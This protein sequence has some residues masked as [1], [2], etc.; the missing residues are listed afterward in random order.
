MLNV[1]DHQANRNEMLSP[2][3]RMAFYQNEVGE[4]VEKRAVSCCTVGGGEN[5]YSNY[6]K[7]YRAS[8]KN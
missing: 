6:G 2:P 8:S 1:T 7:Q 4:D 5:W 3:V